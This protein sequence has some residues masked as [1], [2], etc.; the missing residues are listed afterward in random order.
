[1]ELHED[2]DRV[3]TRED[4]ARFV[5]L[6]RSDLRNNPGDWEN[7]SLEDFLESLSAWLEVMP[8]AYKN[9]GRDITENP[10]WGDVAQILLAAR[11]YE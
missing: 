2:A 10:T 6:L 8:Q 1:M 5:E 7:P 3:A 9:L 11:M 4:L